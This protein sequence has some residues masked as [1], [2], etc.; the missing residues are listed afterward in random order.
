MTT[1]QHDDIHLL[2]DRGVTA[3][4]AALSTADQ[5]RLRNIV[6]SAGFEGHDVGPAERSRLVE[7]FAGRLTGDEARTQILTSIPEAARRPFGR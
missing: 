4:E 7:L 3:A 6:A 5:L 1:R 2:D